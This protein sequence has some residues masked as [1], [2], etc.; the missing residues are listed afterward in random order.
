VRISKRF[1]LTL[2]MK[3]AIPDTGRVIKM[4]REDVVV[5]MKHEVSCRKCGAA[6]H[7]MCTAGFTQVLIARNLMRVRVGDTVKR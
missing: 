6:A 4:E 5:R 3:P 1:L 7:G 2:A